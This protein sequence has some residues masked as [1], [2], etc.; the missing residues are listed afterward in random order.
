MNKIEGKVRKKNIY[1]LESTTRIN[2]RE[3][4]ENHENRKSC[5]S[6]VKNINNIY[7]NNLSARTNDTEHLFF[8][9]DR[10]KKIENVEALVKLDVLDLHG[11]QVT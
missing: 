4:L 3:K 1:I 11:N 8:L 5:W 2:L 10:I 6:F 9:F 7:F